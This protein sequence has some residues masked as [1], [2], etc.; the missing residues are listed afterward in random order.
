LHLENRIGKLA[1]G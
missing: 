1:A